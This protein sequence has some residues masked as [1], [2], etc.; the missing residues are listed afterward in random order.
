MHEGNARRG[1]KVS[2]LREAGRPV[3]SEEAFRSVK[4]EE[5]FRA[6]EEKSS[7]SK[8]GAGRDIDVAET[9]V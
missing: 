8:W 9:L 6:G 4:S 7:F 3:K 5:A 1:V 2:L